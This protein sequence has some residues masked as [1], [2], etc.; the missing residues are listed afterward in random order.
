MKK[1]LL[2]IVAVL[3]IAVGGVFVAALGQPDVL[4]L[5]RSTVVAA[6]PA[7]I[8]PLAN[9]LKEW[10]RWNPWQDL[11]PNQKTAFSETTAGV[12]AWYT[13]EGNDQVGKGRMSVTVAE[14]D[15]KVGHRIE[16][17]EPVPGTAETVF[18]LT[19]EGDGTTVT[20]SFE[21][22]NPFMS[23]VFGLFYDMEAMI[24]AYFEKGLA[25]LKPLAEERAKAREE[26]ERAK[27]AAEQ[28]AAGTEGTAPN[29]GAAP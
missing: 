23:K 15:R 16:F 3:A 24:G 4:K 19:P 26:A 25:R 17:I 29:A 13:W 28:A 2:G 27:A 11:D 18:L 5:S 1:I 10:I 22:P 12:G 14:V 9:D 8:Y 20:W 21:S 6:T 7:D